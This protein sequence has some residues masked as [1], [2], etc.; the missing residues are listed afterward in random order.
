MPTTTTTVSGQQSIP[1][2]LMPYFNAAETSPG[3]GNQGILPRSRELTTRNYDTVYGNALNAANLGGAN[4]IAALSP[5]QTQVGDTLKN[6]SLDTGY[7]QARDVYSGMTNADQVGRY[8]NPYLQLALDPQIRQATENAR[9]NSVAQDRGSARAGSYGGARNI[10]AQQ[11]ANKNLQTNLSDIVGKGYNTAYE[12]AMKTQFSQAQGLSDVAT[13]S[14]GANLANIQAQGAYGDL[15][16]GIQQQQLD[17]QYSDLMRK[18]DFPMEQVGNMANILRGVPIIQTG[19]QTV[20]QTPPPS[21]ASQLT[22][23]LQAMYGL[24]QLSKV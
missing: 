7:R 1:T 2:E 10:L 4:R 15:Q 22:G 20:T 14:T 3:A 9:I 13:K 8:M 21:F 24:N 19:G 18:Q 23:G 16:R 11:Q 6:L 5:M 12:N 17:T